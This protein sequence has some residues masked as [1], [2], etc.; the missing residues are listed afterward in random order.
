MDKK[1]VLISTFMAI[2]VILILVGTYYYLQRVS[3]RGA[4]T[5]SLVKN[6][7]DA[8]KPRAVSEASIP[9]SMEGNEYSINFWVYISDYVYRYEADKVI[10]NRGNNPMIYLSKK[11]NNLVVYTEVAQKFVNEEGEDSSNECVVKNV[12]LQRWVNVNVTLNNNVVDIFFDAKLVKSC[13]LDGYSTPNKGSM[14]ICPDGGYN[15]FI[16]RVTFTNRALSLS[17][18]TKMYKSGPGL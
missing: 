8:K 2:I 14:N 17:E 7:E 3:I 6:V 18:L 1:S 10:I 5:K 11:T 15:G 4:I 9:A 12:P 13:V 16:S